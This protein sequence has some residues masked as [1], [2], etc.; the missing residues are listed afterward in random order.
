[1]WNLNLCI[2]SILDDHELYGEQQYFSL[3]D[4]SKLTV[5]LNS[6]IYSCIWEENMA[7]SKVPVTQGCLSC[8]MLLLQRNR[9]KSFLKEEDLF[10]KYVVK[11]PLITT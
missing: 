7:V 8:L 2:F 1:M 9:R 6:F 4:L 11:I 5:F 3:E 10:I